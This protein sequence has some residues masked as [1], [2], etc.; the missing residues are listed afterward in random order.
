MATV[1][2]PFRSQFNKIDGAVITLV[3]LEARKESDA[4]KTPKRANQI[5]SLK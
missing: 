4:G 1:A 5:F 3:D 2:Y